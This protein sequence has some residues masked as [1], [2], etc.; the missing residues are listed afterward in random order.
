M[1]H[2]NRVIALYLSLVCSFNI[3]GPS[4]VPLS[5]ATSAHYL[6]YGGEAFL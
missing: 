6:L 5:T 3:P 4:F 2:S 1:L